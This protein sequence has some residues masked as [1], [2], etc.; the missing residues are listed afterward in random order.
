MADLSKEW[1]FHGVKAPLG[2]W[3]AI[4]ASPEQHHK[5]L[6][7]GGGY[8]GD[9]G[10][11]YAIELIERAKDELNAA[12]AYDGGKHEVIMRRVMTLYGKDRMARTLGAV[13]SSLS[14]LSIDVRGDGFAQALR[15]FADELGALQR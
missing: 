6:D 9:R 13:A 2:M 12:K 5:V 1:E 8:K 3:V 11:G 10:A 15:H 4:G 7:F 14:D